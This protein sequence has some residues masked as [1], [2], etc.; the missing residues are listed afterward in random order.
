MNEVGVLLVDDEDFYLKL[1]SDILSEGEVN[2]TN[3]N[4]GTFLCQSSGNC[5]SYP[6]TGAG[7]NSHL[8]L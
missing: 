7:D 2:I 5:L 8:L 6:S 1:F 4:P 3:N